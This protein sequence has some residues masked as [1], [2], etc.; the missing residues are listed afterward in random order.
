MAKSKRKNNRALK[1]PLIEQV[2][3]AEGNLFQEAWEIPKYISNNL[4]H[5]LRPYQNEALNNYHYTQ[6]QI[7]PNPQHVLFN[8][9]TGSGKTDLMAALILYLYQDKNYTNFLFTVNSN[10][11]FF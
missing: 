8:M 9:A 11:R 2:E 3:E 5:T 10:N 6:T 7:K 4:I 1:F